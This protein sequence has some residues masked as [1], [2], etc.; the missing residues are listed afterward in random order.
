MCEKFQMCPQFESAF[1]ILSK[2]WSGLI[3]RVL[4]E[5]PKRFKDISVLIPNISDRMLIERFREL[6][7]EGIL[8]RHV[9]PEVPVRI[10]YELTEKGRMLKPAMDE[11]HKWAKT[12]SL[13]KEEVET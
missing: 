1:Q 8:V 13:C 10:E 6:E 7:A 5:G 12:W 2:R 4:L 3:I 9:Y 11:I